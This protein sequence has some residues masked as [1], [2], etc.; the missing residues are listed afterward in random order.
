[1]LEIARQVRSAVDHGESLDRVM[2]SFRIVSGEARTGVRTAAKYDKVEK[3]IDRLHESKIG[4]M[5]PHEALVAGVSIVASLARFGSE[6]VAYAAAST[7]S[8]GVG[9]GILSS[10]REKKRIKDERVQ[11]SERWLRENTLKVVPREGKR[12]RKRDMKLPTL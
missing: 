8:I 10:L 1:M 2:G 7:I 5:V 9:A 12:L 4:S 11:H 3:T 6:K